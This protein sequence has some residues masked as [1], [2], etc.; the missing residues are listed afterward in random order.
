M[1]SLSDHQGILNPMMEKVVFHHEE[2][3][4]EDDHFLLLQEEKKED[5]DH[6]HYQQHQQNHLV[7]LKTFDNANWNDEPV[8]ND[9][10]N[11]EKEQDDEEEDSQE[12]NKSYGDSSRYIINEEESY[13]E[14]E[15]IDEVDLNEEVTNDISDV[16]LD[17]EKGYLVPNNEDKDGKELPAQAKE[18]AEAEGGG[19]KEKEDKEVTEKQEQ[20]HM[21][22]KEEE[23]VQKKTSFESVE[24]AAT[25][26]TIVEKRTSKSVKDEWN[27]LLLKS[28]DGNNDNTVP[29][30]PTANSE[31]KHEAMP[32][33]MV[34]L[35]KEKEEMSSNSKEQQ[36]EKSSLISSP[37]HDG[38]D[39]KEMTSFEKARFAFQEK[40]IEES[41]VKQ[42]NKGQ[43]PSVTKDVKETE[44][45]V[46]KAPTTTP[47]SISDEE[48][49]RMLDI[50][51]AEA[52]AVEQQQLAINKECSTMT[53]VAPSPPPPTINTTAPQDDLGLL[54]TE[55]DVQ[56]MIR[57]IEEE[58]AE[59]EEV[60]R[61][62]RE[63]AEEAVGEEEVQRMLRE[64]AEEA[65]AEIASKSNLQKQHAISTSI[66]EADEDEERKRR[67]NEVSG[68]VSV[69][70]SRSSTNQLTSGTKSQK[71]PF[72]MSFR[73]RVIANL[74]K[75]DGAIDDEASS[76][77]SDPKVGATLQSF[78][79][80]FS[81]YDYDD[82]E[83]VETEKM[84][85]R[86]PT[87]FDISLMLNNVRLQE[88]KQQAAFQINLM[89]ENV[90]LMA[91]DA[92]RKQKEKKRNKQRASRPNIHEA[93]EDEERRRRED[94]AFGRL[95]S[96]TAKGG[97]SGGDMLS[98]MCS[99][100]LCLCILLLLLF[101]PAAGLIY[102]FHFF[103]DSDAP[104]HPTFG[105]ISS[106]TSAPTWKG[107]P[108]KNPEPS[109]APTLD[110]SIP[111]TKFLQQEYGVSAAAGTSADKAINWLV[112]EAYFENK[113]T[114]DLTPKTVQRFALL[115]LYFSLYTGGS[116]GKDVL[117]NWGMRNQDD[118]LWTGI[119]C[120]DMGQVTKIALNDL[121]L[122]G[123]LATE[124]GL[125]KTL[126][127]LDV[128]KNKIKG[129]IPEEIYDLTALKQMFLYHNELSGTI[130][131]KIGNLPNITHFHLSHN[132][133]SGEIPNEIQG[134]KEIRK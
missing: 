6:H 21:N 14:E 113:D 104:E 74:R 82:A 125:L 31:V 2:E 47:T 68:K 134:N 32:S 92:K 33:N 25:T 84:D 127:H 85:N 17:I 121:N 39:V 16:E 102:Y 61:M 123:T 120:N 78:K 10:Y 60:Q 124:L 67:E 133:L 11:N 70:A 116:T 90:K 54:Y 131:T 87:E 65:D 91:K 58:A 76:L 36:G 13:Y 44:V 100:R 77:A 23:E 43:H 9:N 72:R 19:D 56:R 86:A 105:P 37:S 18:E 62:V 42:N 118:C 50:I 75:D 128:A 12:D 98:D 112:Q 111:L 97:G 132:E 89:M 96:Q 41:L 55:D 101:I 81:E 30:E 109:M 3:K 49:Q 126:E 24:E 7:K 83:S 122:K 103:D 45:I 8:L 53:V 63:I 57:K 52:A 64:I 20:D 80:E 51:A 22:M 34:D 1:D 106:P 48:L 26:E 15:S 38:I 110:L 95:E 40:E 119:K 115:V 129:K 29:D 71:K 66:H 27:R 4:K 88:E 5:D 69:A 79:D 28:T 107:Q 130:S 59:E 46:P 73:D 94:E 117:P 108:T 99:R 93:D 114:I 35:L